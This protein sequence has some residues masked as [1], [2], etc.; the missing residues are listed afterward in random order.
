MIR[1]AVLIFVAC[2]VSA[3]IAAASGTVDDR[4]AQCSHQR[5]SADVPPS[6]EAVCLTYEGAAYPQVALSKEEIEARRQR[7]KENSRRYN[8]ITRRFIEKQ[9]GIIDRDP[10]GISWQE[11]KRLAE[12]VREV[13]P[14]LDKVG[15]TSLGTNTS[16]VHSALRRHKKRAC[17]I[18]KKGFLPDAEIAFRAM[19]LEN[20]CHNLSK[21]DGQKLI[22]Q[23]R[24][25][26]S[27]Q[28]FNV[29]TRLPQDPAMRRC[30]VERLE[31]YLLGGD[32][33]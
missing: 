21:A 23:Y 30:I 2:V 10:C 27:R 25:R 17:D 32:M 29:G 22:A 6:H 28:E 3:P 13:Q 26:F 8:Q 19:I 20:K 1:R 33:F 11:V 9:A 7:L 4:R 31:R 15:Y 24:N 18:R 14:Q 12:Q 5:P 16:N